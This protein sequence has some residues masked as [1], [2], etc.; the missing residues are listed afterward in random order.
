MNT[1]LNIAIA[2]EFHLA[3]KLIAY[4]EQSELNI[5]QLKIIEIYPFGEEQN[6]RFNHKY[7]AHQPFEQI[8]WA[9]INYLLFAGDIEQVKLLPQATEAGCVVID[10][11]SVCA[12]LVDI[13][14]VV[15]SINDEQLINLRT[16]NIVCLPDPQV[17][18]LALTLMPLSNE[19]IQQILV[20]SL[21]PA[22]YIGQN[23]VEQ[24]VGQTAQLL[25][26]IPLDQQQTRLA[27]NVLPQTIPYLTNQLNK[28][29]PQLENVIFHQVQTP[30]F[31]G[32]AQNLTIKFDYLMDKQAIIKQWQQHNLIK[33]Y[34]QPLVTPVSNGEMENDEN[35]CHLHIS[36]LSN[37]ENQLNLWTVC[38]EQRFAQAQLAVE[39]LTLIYQQD[40]YSRL[41]LK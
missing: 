16:H 8:E 24:L 12:S 35:Y 17:S 21:L 29:F 2:A 5:D 10:I 6:I 31:Y 40:Y 23:Q 20:T 33:Y 30:V 15:P 26:G 9:K 4:L 19:N 3:N 38:D 39:L 7:I 13:P 1:S 36:E 27:F 34:D 32:L 11:N 14:V 18:Q 41:N 25:N 22:A 37:A 28:I